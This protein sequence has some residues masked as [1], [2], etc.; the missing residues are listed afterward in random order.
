MG[1]GLFPPFVDT[2]VN[3]A[4]GS[5][6]IDQRLKKRLDRIRDHVTV[7]VYVA[8]TSPLSAPVMQTAYAYALENQRLKVTVIEVEEFPRVAQALQISAVPYTI[9]ND[10][11]RFA[12]ALQPEAFLEMIARGAEGRGLTAAESLLHRPLGPTTPLAQ[13]QTEQP[14]RTAGGLILPGRG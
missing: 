2:L 3:A 7:R 6:G 11:L 4:R 9:V 5:T 1:A 10:R 8:L 12:G 13:P 14:Q